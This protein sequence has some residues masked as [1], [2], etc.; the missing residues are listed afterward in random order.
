MTKDDIKEMIDDER[1]Q[2]RDDERR[3]ERREVRYKIKDTRDET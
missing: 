2:V 1:L 3:D